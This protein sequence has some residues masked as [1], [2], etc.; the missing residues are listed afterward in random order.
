VYRVPHPVSVQTNGI[1]NCTLDVHTHELANL[2]YL[3]S[4]TI[5]VVKEDFLNF[6]DN[7]L[8]GWAMSFTSG[9][10]EVDLVVDFF[11]K[12]INTLI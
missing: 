6:L 10:K 7:E 9:N 3:S 12:K 5:P 4:S 1:I 2:F 8:L 11:Y